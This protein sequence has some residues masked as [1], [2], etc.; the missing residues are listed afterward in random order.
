MWCW[1]I[2]QPNEYWIVILS[3]FPFSCLVISIFSWPFLFCG[4]QYTCLV[5]NLFD[6]EDKDQ[7]HCDGCGICRIGGRTNFFHCEVCNMCLPLQLKTN[8]HRV[9]VCLVQWQELNFQSMAFFFHFSDFC[10]SIIT[11]KII[12]FVCVFLVC[13]EC[14]T[15]ELSGML[16]RYTHISLSMSYSWLRSFVAQD[17]LRPVG[18]RSAAQYSILPWLIWPHHEFISSRY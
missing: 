6:D 12:S 5:C 8:G 10:S 7:Y 13:G 18:K 14:I 9:S 17:M 16:G 4:F 11:K 1:R 15:F 3:F 2:W